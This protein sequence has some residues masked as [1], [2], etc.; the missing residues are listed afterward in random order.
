MIRPVLNLLA[1]GCIVLSL[2]V[3]FVGQTTAHAAPRKLPATCVAIP[4]DLFSTTDSKGKA[5]MCGTVGVKL[6]LGKVKGSCFNTDAD[7]VKA[8]KAKYKKTKRASDKRKYTDLTK[9]SS[10]NGKLCKAASTV[11]GITPIPTPTSTPAPV[12][13]ENPLSC[14]TSA[15]VTKAGCFGIPSGVTGSVVV[16][17]ALWSSKGCTSCHSQG[18]NLNKSY[19]TLTSV[20]PISPMY[21]NTTVQERAD[22]T[23]YSNRFQD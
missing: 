16:G 19:S 13:T 1:S 4:A 11:G 7:A 8:A 20:L 6:L 2:A 10:A 18:D 21:I 17:A 12:P 9:K 5:L 3:P 22:L 14:F 15:G 23:A